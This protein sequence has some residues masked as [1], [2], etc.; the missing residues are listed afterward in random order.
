[1]KF[2]EN[3]N[4]NYITEK[5]RNEVK[6]G[7]VLRLEFSPSK[8]ATDILAKLVH[9]DATNKGVALQQLS[10]LSTD[11]TFASEFIKEKGLD[12]II[13]QVRK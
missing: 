1:M 11:V 5:N 6:N 8:I 7:S 4:Q 9:G 10:A 12:L 13:S 2:T 3:N